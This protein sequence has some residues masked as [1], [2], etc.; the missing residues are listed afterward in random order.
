MQA[1]MLINEGI[2]LREFT[3]NNIVNIAQLSMNENY[4]GK[5]DNTHTCRVF[6]IVA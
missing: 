6:L 3:G 5:F 2:L 1:D 4:E